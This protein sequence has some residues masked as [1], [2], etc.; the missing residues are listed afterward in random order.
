MAGRACKVVCKPYLGFRVK[1][2]YPNVSESMDK[3]IDSEMNT[4]VM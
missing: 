4:G 3:N 1:G 2:G